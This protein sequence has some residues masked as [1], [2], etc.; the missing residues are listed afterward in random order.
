[1]LQQR[2]PKYKRT[3]EALKNRQITDRSLDIIT[4]IDRYRVLPSSILLR[5]VD[6]NQRI[7]HRHLQ[8]LFHKGLVSRFSFPTIGSKEFHY[9]L[10]NADALRLLA[11]SGMASD[12][13]LHWDELRYNRD[14]PYSAINDPKQ[15]RE[16]Q[17]R[18]YFIHHEVMIS[19]FHALLELGCKASGG[20]VEL[21][22]WE[23][24]AELYHQVETPKATFYEGLW[25]VGEGI[26]QLPHRP[27]AFFT[28]RFP[29]EPEGNQYAHFFYEADRKTTTESARIIKKLRSHF[30]YVVIKK[31]HQEHYNIKRIRAVLVETINSE[32]ANHLREVARH[33]IVSGSKPSPLFWFTSSEFFTAVKEIQDGAGIKRVPRA[34]LDPTIIFKSIWATPVDDTLYKL[35]D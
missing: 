12:A 29:A 16:G 23:Q 9:Y 7:T 30:H 33:P 27:D 24:G 18:L 4:T 26:Q 3:P 17:S 28:L 1:M 34:L 35:L 20:S 8:A 6:G 15:A 5:L 22:R 11:D 25:R 19:R 21:V 14:R 2:L 13:D 10:E 32:W 31:R